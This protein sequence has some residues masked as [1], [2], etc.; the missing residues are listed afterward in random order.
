MTTRHGIRIAALML[1]A[2]ALLTTLA[3]RTD[4]LFA[5]GLRYIAQAQRWSSGHGLETLRAV[6]HPIYPMAV[7]LA[8]KVRGGEGP[9]SWQAAGQTA[10]VVAGV[11][12]VAPLYL[13]GLELFGSTAAWLTVVLFL[14]TPV[15]GHM[16]A[17]VLSEGTFL[18]FW[19]WGLWAT[20]RFLREG[21][22]GWL[23]VVIGCAGLSYLTRPEGLLLPAA[24]VVSL[25]AMPLLRSTRLYWPRWWAAVGVLLLGPMLFAGPYIAFKGGIGTKP[26]IAR[27][28]GLAPR[29][30]NDA[31][32]RSRPLAAD[33][34][35]VETYAAAVKAVYQA[36]NEFATPA[37]LV[38]AVAGLWSWRARARERSRVVLLLSIMVV[39]AL[40]AL[41]RLHATGG[42]C[43][44]RHASVL[45]VLICAAAAEGLGRALGAVSIPGRWLGQTDTRFTAGPLVWVLV[46]G[47]LAVCNAP[48]I[49]KPL[50]HSMIGYRQAGD[51][52]AE[53]VP[54]QA[55]VADATGWSLFYGERPGYTFATLHN[56]GRDSELR[57]VVARNSHLAGPWWYCGVLRELVGRREPVAVFPPH[58]E[59][60][61]SRVLVFD[62]TSPEVEAVSWLDTSERRH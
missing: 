55:R 20:L 61:Q 48:T 6:D 57:W 60:G 31:V 34:T 56:S 18:L 16:L 10:S 45:A 62:R 23:P 8:H 40:L 53:H 54:V 22:F 4:I 29:S 58:P 49:L 37:L 33:Q 13:V 51:W 1:L 59:P 44:P 9:V 30:P 28:L 42:Y 25:L 2:A 32:E 50:N 47:C 46:L 12:L 14:L 52:L 17:D 15:A 39:M 35:Q 7:A 43:T 38:L 19:L 26:A 36:I 5:D 3:F 21:A 11:L 27:L 24:L 41:V